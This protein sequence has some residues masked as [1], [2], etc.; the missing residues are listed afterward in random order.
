VGLPLASD[1]S[2]RVQA[3]IAIHENGDKRAT[4][5][6]LGIDVRQLTGMLS[7]DWRQFSL[8]ALGALVLTYGV[9]IDWLLALQLEPR[10]RFATRT[11]SANTEVN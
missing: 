8:E 6:R 7:G 3:L 10:P 1:V 4:A 9:S 5:R 11:Q 2:A